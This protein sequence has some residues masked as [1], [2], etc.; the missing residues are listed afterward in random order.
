[1]PIP[2]IA[3]WAVA[4]VGFIV[5]SVIMHKHSKGDGISKKGAKQFALVIGGAFIVIIVIIVLANG[6]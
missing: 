4:A 6:N 1:M 5:G 2:V 3:I